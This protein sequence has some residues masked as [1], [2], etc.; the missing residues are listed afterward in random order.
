M[1]RN[2]ERAELNQFEQAK[3]YVDQKIN[4]AE[5]NVEKIHKVNKVEEEILEVNEN[6]DKKM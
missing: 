1:Q 6:V 2:H 3:L 5:N 4:K